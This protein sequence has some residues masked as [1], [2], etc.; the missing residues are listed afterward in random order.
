MSNDNERKAVIKLMQ[1][2]IR[3][4]SSHRKSMWQVLQDEYFNPNYRPDYNIYDNA[5]KPSPEKPG[6]CVIIC[7][8]TFE[9][10]IGIY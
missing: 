8:E 5:S 9:K 3:F 2:M 4:D 10:V 6:L 1:R 7:Q